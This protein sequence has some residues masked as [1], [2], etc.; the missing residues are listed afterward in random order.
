MVL[1]RR[2]T[3]PSPTFRSLAHAL[4]GLKLIRTYF[5][6]KQFVWIKINTKTHSIVV[7]VVIVGVVVLLLLLYVFSDFISHFASPLTLLLLVCLIN[8]YG[9]WLSGRH[10]HEN[11]SEAMKIFLCY[12][13]RDG[14]YFYVMTHAMVM[15]LVMMLLK[16]EKE[17]K[18]RLVSYVDF[19][20][21]KLVC[22]T[23][24]RLVLVGYLMI[25]YG[26]WIW[27]T[28]AELYHTVAYVTYSATISVAEF[29]GPVQGR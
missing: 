12:D 18:N 10:L 16:L 17:L 1:T 23:V 27:K 29:R 14:K 15:M 11:Q 21:I 8:R 4:E 25:F 20:K 28:V 13:A 6:M 24:R 3:R 26:G 7:V 9:W 22:R 19:K 5:I 2:S